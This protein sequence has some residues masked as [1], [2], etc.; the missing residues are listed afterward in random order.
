[1]RAGLPEFRG[2]RLTQD[3]GAAAAFP[4]L[5][6]V[7]VVRKCASILTDVPGLVGSGSA[8][9]GGNSGFQMLDL[10]VQFG[11]PEVYLVGF[12][13]R[14]D[15]GLHWHGRHPRG[16]NNPAE[17]LMSNWRRALDDAAGRLTELGVRVYNCSP[18]SWLTAYPYRDLKE[19]L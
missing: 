5:H 3:A 4:G 14:C 13:M 7:E 16:M 15:R 19:A 1:M 10:A 18:V 2:L 17:H 12:D 8:S 9:G 6:K 11:S